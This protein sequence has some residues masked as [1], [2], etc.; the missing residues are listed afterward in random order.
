[1]EKVK[2]DKDDVER[3]VKS[4]AWAA[5]SNIAKRLVEDE[6]Q[7]MLLNPTLDTIAQDVNEATHELRGRITVLQG[8]ME[9][10]HNNLNF[11][12]EE[13]EGDNGR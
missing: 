12:V 3:F 13:M 1:M 11:D 8:I 9:T 10:F 6:M 4:S 5:L 7:K 2:L